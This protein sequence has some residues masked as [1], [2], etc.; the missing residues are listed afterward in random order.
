MRVL[1]VDLGSRRIGLAISDDE[2]R[3]AFPLDALESGGRGGDVNS[4]CALIAE[5]GVERVVVGLPLHLDGRAGPEAEKARRFATRLAEASGLPVELLDERWTTAE[6]ERS[7]QAG[8]T[9]KQRRNARKSGARDS[10]AASIILRT[11]L[12]REASRR[13]TAGGGHS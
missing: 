2:A 11:W 10:M 13:P 7:L 3:F 9:R 12:E 6:A 4:L 8:G 5:R 1:G